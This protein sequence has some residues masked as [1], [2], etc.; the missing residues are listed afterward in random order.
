MIASFENIGLVALQFAG[1]A[2]WMQ[3]EQPSRC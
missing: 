2:F 1:L 3:I